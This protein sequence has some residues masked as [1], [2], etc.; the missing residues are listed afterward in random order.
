MIIVVCVCIGLATAP[1]PAA[2]AIS[3][4]AFPAGALAAAGALMARG[5]TNTL[6]NWA[7]TLLRG[8]GAG[9]AATVV[10]DVYL[11]AMNAFSSLVFDPFRA[12]PIFGQIITGMPSTHPLALAAGWG[13]H[14]WVG[15]L[16]GMIFAALRPKGGA[17]TGTIFAAVLQIGRWAMYPHVLR[18]G[19][20][21]QEFFAN[22]I[23]GQLLWGVVL[24]LVLSLLATRSTSES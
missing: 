11:Y 5:Q 19:T 20:S 17:L 8:A 22:G 13:Y 4:A 12:Q 24:G 10:Y 7:K 14:I 1:M 21:D 18:A 16:L 6:S 9:L 23:V 3:L 2:Y 15:L